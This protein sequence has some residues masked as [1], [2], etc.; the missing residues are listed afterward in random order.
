MSEYNDPLRPS[1]EPREQFIFRETPSLEEM[2]P[3]LNRRKNATRITIGSLVAST[4]FTLEAATNFTG[5]EIPTYASY[6]LALSCALGALVKYR[7]VRK[8]DSEIKDLG[9]SYQFSQ[10]TSKNEGT[11]RD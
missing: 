1:S 6:G 5:N 10:D 7:R 4:V 11:G 2:E 3:L 9:L 8:L